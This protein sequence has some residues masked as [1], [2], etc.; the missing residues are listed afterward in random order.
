VGYDIPFREM[1][2]EN[3]HARP[4]VLESLMRSV[5]HW[6]K[7][8]IPRRMTGNKSRSE[9]IG[10][11]LFLLVLFKMIWPHSSYY[12]CI[13]FIANEMDDAK[14]FNEMAVSRALRKLGYTAKI[15]S[16]VANQVFTTRNLIC[17]QQFS[18]ELWPV[19]IHGTPRQRIIDADEFG[20]HLIAA[21]KKYGSAPRGLEIRKPGNYDRGNF[22][23]TILLAVEMGDPAIPG[24]GIGLVTNPHV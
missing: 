17:R 13:T 19:G 22:K 11:Y 1:I 23:L 10:H 6:V 12:K 7:G 21:N 15:T 4:P 3:Y 16:A 20:L 9:L 2:L 18:N 14:I 24:G 8:H 5:K